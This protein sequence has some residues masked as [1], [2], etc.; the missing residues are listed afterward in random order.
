MASFDRLAP[1]L[2][3]SI[4]SSKIVRAHRS[5]IHGRQP[6]NQLHMS[7]SSHLQPCYMMFNEVGLAYGVIMSHMHMGPFGCAAWAG[8]RYIP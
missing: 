2:L 5:T 1:R 4:S 8:V 6:A 7:P 3:L